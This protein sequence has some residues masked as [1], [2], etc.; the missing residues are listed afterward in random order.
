MKA[1][2]VAL[3]VIAAVLV[4]YFATGTAHGGSEMLKARHA[5]IE[6]AAQ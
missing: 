1:A 6:A 5:V 4:A 2:S 3:V